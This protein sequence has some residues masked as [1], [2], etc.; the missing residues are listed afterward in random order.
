MSPVRTAMITLVKAGLL[1]Q[2]S[3]GRLIFNPTPVGRKPA[4]A[5][6]ALPPVPRDWDN[7]LL[8][9]VVRASLRNE[10]VH[11]REE[12][13]A[14]KYRV[15]R[16]IIRHTLSRFAGSRL[17]DHLPRRGWVVQP[18]SI[19]Q[20]RSYVQIREVLELKALDLA[21]SRLE[22]DRLEA[23]HDANVPGRRGR[24]AEL[25]NRLHA[26]IIERSGNRFIRDFFEQYVSRYYTTLFDLAAPETSEVGDMVHQHRDILSALVA[27]DWPRARRALAQHIREQEVILGKLLARGAGRDTPM[28][29]TS[30]SATPPIDAVISAR[31]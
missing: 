1:K 19:Q 24:P 28:L 2:K 10:L 31:A 18:L 23:L 21:R 22:R 11:L 8:Q 14:R 9:E 4:S 12:S 17:L 5:R 26:Y 6:I 27:H 15:G 7:I 29:R 30:G 25:D 13:L 20:L 16:S 3:N